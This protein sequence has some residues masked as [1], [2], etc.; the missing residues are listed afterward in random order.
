MIS[1]LTLYEIAGNSEDINV[2]FGGPDKNG[3]F[4]GWITRGPEQNYRPLVST[5]AIF[6]TSKAAE[7]AMKELVKFANN[8]TEEDLAKPDNPLVKFFSTPEEN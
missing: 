6:A 7:S 5:S 4:C 2:T 1:R 8:F 3:K